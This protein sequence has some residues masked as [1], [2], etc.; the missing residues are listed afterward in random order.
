MADAAYLV[1]PTLAADVPAYVFSVTLL[2]QILLNPNPTV[3]STSSAKPFEAFQLP[4]PKPKPKPADSFSTLRNLFP[5]SQ[6]LK[7]HVTN[8]RPALVLHLRPTIQPP[9]MFSKHKSA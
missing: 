4:Q 1:L 2:L 9:M 6:H 3:Q 8:N 5:S 7:K